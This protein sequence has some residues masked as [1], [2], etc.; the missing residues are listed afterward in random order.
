[1][2]IKIGLLQRKKKMGWGS[3]RTGYCG[4]HLGP[5]GRK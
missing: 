3:S 2:D 5:R 4:R 1:M